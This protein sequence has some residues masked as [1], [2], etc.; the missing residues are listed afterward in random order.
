MPP[1]LLSK[2]Q[3]K[4]VKKN[5]QILGPVRPEGQ[6]Q[7]QKGQQRTRREEESRHG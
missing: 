4:D 5:L 7:A 2:D 6:A 1:T 3:L